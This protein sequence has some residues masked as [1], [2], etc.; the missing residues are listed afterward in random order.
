MDDGWIVGMVPK[1]P[2][3]LTAAGHAM[4]STVGFHWVAHSPPPM[5]L[6]PRIHI[7]H[8][9]GKIF[10]Q[11]LLCS[12]FLGSI[13]LSFTEKHN[14]PRKVVPAWVVYY[15]ALPKNQNRPK[16]ELHG[17]PLVDISWGAGVA[18]VYGKG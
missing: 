9:M 6:H 5:I 18:N 15:N 2:E 11:T 14:R 13:F 16:K 10:T 7:L 8:K 12:S 1:T 17:N 4:H 3:T